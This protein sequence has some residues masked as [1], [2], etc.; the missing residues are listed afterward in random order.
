MNIAYIKMNRDELLEFIERRIVKLS[1]EKTDPTDGLIEEFYTRKMFSAPSS[2][3]DENGTFYLCLDISDS[4][5]CNQITKGDYSCGYKLVKHISQKNCSI[6][7]VDETEQ[8]RYLEFDIPLSAITRI[9]VFIRKEDFNTYLKFFD[10]ILKE[11]EYKFQY[12]SEHFKID[13]REF[14]RLSYSIINNQNNNNE[15]AF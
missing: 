12:D 4:S 5:I 13:E 10:R 2:I 6:H 3:Y 15:K 11:K 14:V 8:N 9:V 7:L 1:L